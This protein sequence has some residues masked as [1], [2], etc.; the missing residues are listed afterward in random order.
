[1]AGT[2]EANRPLAERYPGTEPLDWHGVTVHP[3]YSQQLGTA[4]TVVR[5]TLHASVPPPGLLGL[6]IGLSVLDGHVLLHDRE[7]PGVD[8]WTDAIAEGVEF[9]LVPTGP[10]AGYTLT[11]VW[12]TTSGAVESWTGNYGVVIERAAAGSMVLRCSAGV[13]PPDFGELIVTVSAKSVERRLPGTELYD[14]GIV[15]QGRGDADQARRLL[16]Q[17]ADMGHAGAAYDLGVL[18]YRAREFGEAKQWWRLAAE[19]GDARAMAGLAEVLE[20]QG[21]T[22]AATHWRAQARG[23]H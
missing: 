15:A 8:V 1:M 17:A 12:M 7:L 4:A 22:R 9:R 23:G 2:G 13:G 16:R 19:R 14:R 18:G 5:L 21:D 20:R 6:G 11:P 10:E 3:M